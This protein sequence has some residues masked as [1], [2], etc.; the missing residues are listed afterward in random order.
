MIEVG[1]RLK[2][3]RSYFEDQRESAFLL[4]LIDVLKSGVNFK[5]YL[6]NPKSSIA[7][8]YIEDRARVQASEH[9]LLEEIEENI[10]KLASL[11]RQLNKSGY[12]GRM[13]LFLY[14]HF[15]YQHAVIVDGETANGWMHCSPYLYGISRANAPVLEIKRSANKTLFRKYLRSTKSLIDPPLYDKDCLIIPFYY[16]QI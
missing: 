4:P 16:P 14:D 12:K 6:L 13:E 10:E 3:L 1:I 5:C 8:R 11:F 2:N 15:P 9:N 7:R